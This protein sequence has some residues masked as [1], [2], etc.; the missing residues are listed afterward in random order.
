MFDAVVF[1]TLSLAFEEAGLLPETGSIL[2]LRAEA[3]PFLMRLPKERL[4]CQNSFKP[5]HDALKTAGFTVLPPETERFPSAA[6]VG[7]LRQ[8][9]GPAATR[10]SGWRRRGR[11]NRSLRGRSRARLGA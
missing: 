10:R 6:L 3:V 4:T 2:C 5:D 1:E 8:R 9:P 7:A 11:R